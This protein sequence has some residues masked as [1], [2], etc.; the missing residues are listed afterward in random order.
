MFHPQVPDSSDFDPTNQTSKR[1]TSVVVVMEGLQLWPSTRL[2][3]H[4][5]LRRPRGIHF[6]KPRPLCSKKRWMK[7]SSEAPRKTVWHWKVLSHDPSLV[8]MEIVLWKHLCFGRVNMNSNLPPLGPRP[9]NLSGQ[10]WL[11]CVFGSKSNPPKN[12]P[13]TWQLFFVFPFALK[14]FWI[15]FSLNR[16]FEPPRPQIL[17]NKHIE[18]LS[19]SNSAR[20]PWALWAL[21]PY[22]SKQCLSLTMIPWTAWRRSS[23][24][25]CPIPRR[26][27]NYTK[28]KT[29]CLQGMNLRW[30]RCFKLF[31][32]HP[33][34]L[35][36]SVTGLLNILDIGQ[37]ATKFIYLMPKAH[38]WRFS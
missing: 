29:E 26:S 33:M 32:T 7:R 38:W 23:R 1:Q 36:P 35:V 13:K 3:T 28:Q 16:C 24:S 2:T 4:D 15:P 21:T 8:A 34:I 17:V 22:I 20:T 30:L 12:G 5:G 37:P 11:M 10:I 25:Y 14:T 31:Q 9:L 6:Q 18:A 19:Y 27:K